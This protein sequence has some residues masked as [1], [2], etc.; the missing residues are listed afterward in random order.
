MVKFVG[1]P[2]EGFE[3][4]WQ[5]VPKG[6]NRELVL[7]SGGGLNVIDVGAHKKIIDLKETT[8]GG[9]KM[10][11]RKFIIK[12][13]KAG[14]TVIWAKDSKRTQAQ[15]V[16]EVKPQRVVKI[17]FNYVEDKAGHKTKRTPKTANDILKNLNAI[18]L[19]QANVKFLLISADRL[20]INKDLGQVIMRDKKTSFKDEFSILVKK[21]V[22][23]AQINVFF[24]WECQKQGSSGETEG[25]AEIA[26]SRND[27]T[28]CMVEDSLG[29]SLEKVI[30]HEVGHNLGLKDNYI[31]SSLLM[32]GKKSK[33]TGI[34]LTKSEI[35][36]IN[37]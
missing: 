25:Y 37:S 2:N 28:N 16:V 9:L 31:N 10:Q 17:A 24:V 1:K 21:R 13:L 36:T 19:P 32:Y 3:T 29:S 11:N 12:G 22:Q 15:I 20:K 14:E 7:Q 34:L 6:G 27:K 30:A 35:K 18:F 23:A 8:Q 33:T 5:L 26:I 4:S